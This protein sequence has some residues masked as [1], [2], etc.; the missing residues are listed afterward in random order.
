MPLLVPLA[1]AGLLGTALG[2]VVRLWL[3]TVRFHVYTHP[4]L[5]ESPSHRWVLALWH[6]E[7]F[8]LLGHKRRGL[9]AALVSLSPDGQ[10]LSGACRWFGLVS[11]RGSSSRGGKEGL[12]SVVEHIRSGRDAAFAVDGPRGPKEVPRPGALAAAARSGA[13]VVPYAAACSRA[14]ALGT[15]DRLLVPWPFCR[16]VVVLGEPI[17]E[18]GER[19]IDELARRIGKASMMA[20]EILRR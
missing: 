5:L 19:S 15:W 7:I 14:T 3:L 20:Q 18:S 16:I 1:L 4:L 11:A 9:T 6:G 2:L 12:I 8:L 10:L 17:V 13:W